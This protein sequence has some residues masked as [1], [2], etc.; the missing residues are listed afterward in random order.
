MKFK[1]NWSQPKSS[2]GKNLQKDF[3]NFFYISKGNHDL[4]N[5]IISSAYLSYL[6]APIRPRA[7]WDKV[8]LYVGIVQ[9]A[10]GELGGHPRQALD[11]N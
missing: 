3:V 9:T 10:V 4:I 2:Y 8:E 1:P 5:L 11:G 7:A 6:S